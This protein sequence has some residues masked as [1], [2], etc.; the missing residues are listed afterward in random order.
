MSVESS[1][2]ADVTTFDKKEAESSRY[3]MSVLLPVLVFQ[4]LLASMAFPVAK[5]GLDFLEP[6]TYAF[7]RFTLAAVVLFL[8]LKFRTYPTPIEKRDVFKLIGLGL[9]I[10]PLNQTVY[11]YGQR[12]TAAGHGALLFATVPLW[13]FIL[14]MIHLKEK[15]RWRRVIGL[16]VAL[17]GVY[18]VVSTGALEISRAYFYGDMLILVAALTWAYYTIL[19]KPLVQKYGA[20]RTTAWA[21]IS[22]SVCYFPFGL[23]RALHFDYSQVTWGGWLSVIYMAIGTSIVAYSLWYWLLRRM[24]ASRLA[25]YQNIQPVL[26]S[27]I[28]FYFLSEPLGWSFVIGGIIVL[29]GVMFAEL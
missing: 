14:A 3:G 13:I 9:L 26:A 28:A 6:F 15:L 24:D 29:G 20:F 19:G 4:Q 16:V 18:I 12:L 2:I 27:V 7:F 1:R 10:I 17:T 22:G 8:I 11:L 23:Y 5:Y 25:V 21:L